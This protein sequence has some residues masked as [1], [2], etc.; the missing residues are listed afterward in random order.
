[1]TFPKTTRYAIVFAYMTHDVIQNGKEKGS[2]LTKILKKVTLESKEN[3]RLLT[4]LFVER[5]KVTLLF[6]LSTQLYK[7]HLPRIIPHPRSTAVSFESYP[8]I[9]EQEQCK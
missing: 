1:M 6:T 7:T 4:V 9:Q 3:P 2:R 5:N 8:F